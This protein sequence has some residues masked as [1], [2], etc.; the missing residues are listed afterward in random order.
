[1]KKK[2][3][4]CVLCTLAAIMSP[5][6]VSYVSAQAILPNIGTSG[7][8]ERQRFAPERRQVRRPQPSP[9]TVSSRVAT[10][11][12]AVPCQKVFFRV[13]SSANNVFICNPTPSAAMVNVGGRVTTASGRGISKA[14]IKMT[15]VEGI[16]RTTYT[17]SSGY[18][19]FAN[20]KVGQVLIFG[21]NHQSSK[22]HQPVQVISLMDQMTALDFIGS[23]IVTNERKVSRNLRP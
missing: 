19:N 22:F 21:I 7:G 9:T 14:L 17:T 16:A 23:P 5:A 8:G 12:G 6:L 18:Y 10:I 13:G 3:M 1:M 2:I 11:K 4:L 15:N 20:V